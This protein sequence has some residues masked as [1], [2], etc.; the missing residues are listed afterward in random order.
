MT[1]MITI[2]AY[3]TWEQCSVLLPFSP[4]SISPVV[5]AYLGILLP[6]ILFDII[7]FYL[8]HKVLMKNVGDDINVV[9]SKSLD[10]PPMDMEYATSSM[11]NSLYDKN[12]PP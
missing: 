12:Y 5:P 3:D 9:N 6:F 10:Y 1:S 8:I 2:D 4:H 7:F 11:G